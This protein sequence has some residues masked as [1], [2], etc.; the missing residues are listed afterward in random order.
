LRSRGDHDRSIAKPRIVLTTL[1]RTD[2]VLDRALG[3]DLLDH[4]LVGADLVEEARGGPSRDLLEGAAHVRCDELRLLGGEVDELERRW[5]PENERGHD[6]RFGE[7]E[8]ADGLDIRDKQLIGLAL[9][10]IEPPESL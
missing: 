10:G 2:E 5:I 9:R 8:V 1:R 6:A 3:V 7:R 4:P